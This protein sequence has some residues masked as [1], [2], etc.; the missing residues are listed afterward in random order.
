MPGSTVSVFGKPDEYEAALR[1]DAAVDL[2]VTGRG[3]FRAH[4]TRIALNHMNLL[5]GKET[6][7][8]IAFIRLDPR[9][10]R[11]S[12]PVQGDATLFL[13]GIAARPGEIVT[14]GS[15]HS[16]HE[17]TDGPCRWRVISLPMPASQP[18]YISGA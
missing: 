7:S 6:L 13:D 17:R 14:H 11:V 15:G 5:A 2:L 8:R 16:L 18:R 1:T 10:V 12:L 9:I 3:E 4:L